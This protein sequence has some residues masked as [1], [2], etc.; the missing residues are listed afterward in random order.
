[1]EDELCDY[2]RKGLDDPEKT[3]RQVRALHHHG[4]AMLA[5]LAEMAA[6]GPLLPALRNAL[7]RWEWFLAQMAQHPLPRHR[8][9]DTDL[10]WCARRIVGALDDTGVSL[11]LGRERNSPVVRCLRLFR[12]WAAEARG[13][14]PSQNGFTSADYD[15][16]KRVTRAYLAPR[17]SDKS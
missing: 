12:D 13:K 5:I 2:Q 4:T 11:H 17:C 16:A 14:K 3:L 15:F 8:V 7:H 9:P 1:M 10:F 6:H